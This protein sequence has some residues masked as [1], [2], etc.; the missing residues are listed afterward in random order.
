MMANIRSEKCKVMKFVDIFT[1]LN[2]KVSYESFQSA[3]V[4]PES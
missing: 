3:K 4:P 2:K 1:A